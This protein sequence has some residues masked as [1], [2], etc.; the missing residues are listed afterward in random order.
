MCAAE[1]QVVDAADVLLPRT[2]QPLVRLLVQFQAP[3]QTVPNDEVS[4]ILQIQSMP[5][6]RRMCQRDGNLTAI[7]RIDI[8]RLVQSSA[9]DA[10]SDADGIVA[11]GVEHENRIARRLPQSS[12]R[13]RRA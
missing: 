10:L 11:I 4:A 7:P 13:E 12:L 1:N 5:Y 6:A 9:V 3:R 8:G 2:V